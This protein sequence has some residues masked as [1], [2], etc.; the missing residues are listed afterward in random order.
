MH[1]AVISVVAL[2]R[3]GG[4]QRAPASVPFFFTL[5]SLVVSGVREG[6][7]LPCVF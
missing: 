3:A 4:A 5:W 2:R 1:T 6:C 7:E